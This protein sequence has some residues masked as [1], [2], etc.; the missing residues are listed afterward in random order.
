METFDIRKSKVSGTCTICHKK[1]KNKIGI[2]TNCGHLIDFDCFNQLV[3]FTGEYNLLK[4]PLCRSI[5][6]RIVS[7]YSDQEEEH[8]ENTQIETSNIS[9]LPRK[10]K[11][12]PA[13]L[14]ELHK[15]IWKTSNS[16]YGSFY[17]KK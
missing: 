3:K 12:H 5:I 4:C 17:I 10:T 9:I 6:K 15:N 1:F 7:P 14:N 2:K 11:S 16:D 13:R 8:L